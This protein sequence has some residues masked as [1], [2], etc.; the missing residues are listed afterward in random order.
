M[1]DVH[2]V[3]I[4]IYENGLVHVVQCAYSPPALITNDLKT[5]TDLINHICLKYHFVIFVGDFNL[6]FF[7]EKV[8][9]VPYYKFSTLAD[10]IIEFVLGY[11]NLFV[12]PLGAK[13]F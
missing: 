6:P 5:I 8:N 7:T 9:I 1:N 11:N 12:N 4:E 2:A 13:I 10:G 3:S